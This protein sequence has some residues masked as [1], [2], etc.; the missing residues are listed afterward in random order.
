MPRTAFRKQIPPIWLYIA[1]M[2]AG[3]LLSSRKRA[4]SQTNPPTGHAL[5]LSDFLK[6]FYDF[7]TLPAYASGTFSAEESTYDRT[8]GNNDGF[9]GTYSYLRRNP[10]SSLVLLDLNGPGLINRIWTPTPTSDSLD[11]YI[12]DSL[13]TAFTIC[14][15]DL[16]SGKV[17]PFIAPLCANQLGG[18]YCYLPIPFSKS[19]RIVLR[20]KLARF[21]QIGYR[22]YPPQTRIRKFSLPLDDEQ[23]QAISMVSSRWGKIPPPAGYDLAGKKNNFLSD[24]QVTLSP[25]Q[26]R[27]VFNTSEPGRING[28]ELTSSQPLDEV[29]RD[30][31]LKISWDDEKFPAVYCP[32]ADFFGYAFGSP[33][34]KS[35]L[36]GSSAGL[37]YCYF[38]MPFDQ[39]ARIELC[40]RQ[41]Q[42]QTRGKSLAFHCRVYYTGQ[43][44]NAQKEGKFYAAWRRQNPVPPGRPY[45]MLDVRG[46]GHYVGTVLQAQGL[47]T[48]MTTFFEGDDSAVAD[49]SLRM[50]GTGSEDY[51]NGGWYALLDCWDAAMSLPL[52]GSLTYSIP[53]SRTGGY[54]LFLDD[55]ISFEKSYFQSIEHGG[56]NNQV[57]ADY[58]SVSYYYCSQPPSGRFIPDNSNT[59]IVQLDTLM[60][61]PQLM[62]FSVDGP[63]QVESGWDYPTGGLTYY[64]TVSEST[65]LRISLQ[66][67]PAGQYEVFLDYV[68]G[69]QSASFSLFQRQTQLGDW[70]DAHYV[71]PLRMERHL[72]TKLDVTDLNNTVSF[73]FRTGG[74][75]LKFILNRIILVK[76]P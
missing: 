63:L 32:L 37:H 56:E 42:G 16:F 1:L 8:G 20:G 31:D 15:R 13:H 10:D 76:K 34:M 33:S 69:P 4:F 9:Q 55:K 68:K 2:T 6:T 7:S 11:F 43:K 75:P 38:P 17:Y 54:R 71:Q 51:F 59:R 5:G 48:G 29:S 57:P 60:L 49:G 52:S 65:I 40:Y 3:L 66:G 23:A 35:L 53:L 14:Y 41:R 27:T 61:Y 25:G 58:S 21:H 44:R 12:D 47:K 24:R 28:I 36:T 18:Y 70:I 67:I 62:N 19:C 45:T 50:H 72:I 64:Y 39:S 26:C 30:I 22:L 46:R 74:M 73:H